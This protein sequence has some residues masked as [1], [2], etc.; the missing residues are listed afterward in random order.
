VTA[1]LIDRTAAAEFLGVS[2]GTLANWQSTGFRRVPHVKIGRRVRYRI[3]DLAK[4]IEQNLVD[5]IGAD[6]GNERK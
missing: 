4:F 6:Q 1:E 3:S 2:P 5:P